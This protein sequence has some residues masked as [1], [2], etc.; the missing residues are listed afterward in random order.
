MEVDVADLPT[1]LRYMEI[2]APE[3]TS[4]EILDAAS[5]DSHWVTMPESTESVGDEW[6]SSGRTALLQVPSAIVPVTSNVIVNPE[7]PDSAAIRVAR[8]HRHRIDS[9]LFR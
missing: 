8:I 2:E 5:L 4:L 9:R 3:G 7:H 6:L 1:T